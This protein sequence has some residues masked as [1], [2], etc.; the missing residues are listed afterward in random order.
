MW[1][2]SQGYYTI[3][4]PSAGDVDIERKQRLMIIHLARTRFFRAVVNRTNV[5]TIS[6]AT[7]GKHEVGDH[8][9][10]FERVDTILN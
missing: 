6:K 8:L 3:N 4:I 10:F 5:R 7:L 2:K 1:T 9:G